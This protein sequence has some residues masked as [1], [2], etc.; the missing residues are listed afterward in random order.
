MDQNLLDVLACPLDKAD[1]VLSKDKK[2]LQ[3]T[4]CKKVYQ[5]KDGIPVMM[6]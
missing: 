3:C 4:K 6:P 2:S 5:I 1:V